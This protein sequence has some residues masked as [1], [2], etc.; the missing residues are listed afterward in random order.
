MP[1]ITLQHFRYKTFR[2]LRNINIRVIWIRIVAILYF[3]V[4]SLHVI[5]FKWWSAHGQ[6]ISDDPEAPDVDLE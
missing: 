6:G 3:S 2:I 4:C 5:S 1:R